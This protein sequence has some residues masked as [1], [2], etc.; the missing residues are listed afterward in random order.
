MKIFVY[1]YY[2]DII[3]LNIFNCLNIKIEDINYVERKIIENREYSIQHRDEILKYSM[4]FD[5]VKVLKKHY[6]SSIENI[7]KNYEIELKK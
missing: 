3:F 4:N 2:F 7:I 5:W 1:F 6:I